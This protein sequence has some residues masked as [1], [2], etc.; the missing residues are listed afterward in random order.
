M[1]ALAVSHLT[2]ILRMISTVTIADHSLLSKLYMYDSFLNRYVIP[3]MKNS[4]VG[5][6][7]WM[8]AVIFFQLSAIGIL[9]STCLIYRQVSID[10]R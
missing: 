3:W 8:I 1:R 5:V 7:Y 9:T 2:V 4:R 10:H 6:T